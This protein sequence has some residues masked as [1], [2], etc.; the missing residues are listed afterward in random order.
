MPV[1]VCK[2]N[3]QGHQAA[4][5]EDVEANNNSLENEEE[6]EEVEVE[7]VEGEADKKREKKEEEK[8][9]D[10]LRGLVTSVWMTV[11]NVGSFVGASAGGAA[12]D[13]LGKP[14]LERQN[15]KSQTDRRPIF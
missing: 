15:F 5:V 3:R 1:N 2:L 12:Y 11:D 9:E 7:V 6:E 4:S 10:S 8:E 14:V 13:R